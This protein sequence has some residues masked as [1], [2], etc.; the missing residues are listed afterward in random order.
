MWQPPV[1]SRMT[2]V[3]VLFWPRRFEGVLLML[4]SAREMSSRSMHKARAESC[5]STLAPPIDF[6]AAMTTD[7]P[8]VAF[9]HIGMS[10]SNFLV[11][12]FGVATDVVIF[13]VVIV[14]PQVLWLCG[15]PGYK[16]KGKGYGTPW[17]GRWYGPN[18]WT[19]PAYNNSNDHTQFPM[20]HGAN[21]TPV[22]LATTH[23]PTLQRQ[24][25]YELNMGGAYN[26]QEEECLGDN[27]STAMCFELRP[28]TSSTASSART[29]KST[30]LRETLYGNIA[31]NHPHYAG[32][33]A[34]H[35]LED[36]INQQVK[37]LLDL[38]TQLSNAINNSLNIIYKTM[39]R[40]PTPLK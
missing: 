19:Y 15:V 38:L 10:C 33:I 14:R 4:G 8:N 25:V 20:N 36:H 2:Y 13:P 35:I 24:R 29:D 12:A 17:T 27:W 31:S 11:V 16:A 3:A 37:H 23:H 22:H 6:Y 9:S 1:L 40:T 5:V 18:N 7:D 30:D 26:V 34:Q 39:V 28:P 21:P 32:R